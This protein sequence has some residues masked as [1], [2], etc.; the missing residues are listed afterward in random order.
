MIKY[1]I[2][3][4]GCAM[5]YSD[6][7]RLCSI[8]DSC[9]GKK[10]KT[11]REA[12]LLLCNTCSI[13]QKSEDKALGF[14]HQTKK[15]L[16]NIKIVLSGC[17]VR[18][19]GVKAFGSDKLLKHRFIDATVRIEDLAKMPKILSPLFPSENFASFS[20]FYDRGDID[21]YFHIKPKVKNKYQVSVPIMRGCDNFCTY[22]IV[23]LTRG[24]EISR[25]LKE[26]ISECTALVKNGAQELTLVGQ[27]VNSYQIK[28]KKC[29]PL[30]LQEIDKLYNSGLRWL[31]FVSPNPRDWSE[32][33]TSILAQMRLKFPYLHLPLQ[34]GSDHILHKMNRGY[35]K[36]QYISLV[37]KIR[38]KLPYIRI[39]TDIIVGFPGES[40]ADFAS[41]CALAQELK[42]DFVYL[43]IFSP[44][45]GTGAA[46]MTAEFI[47][48]KTKKERF[49]T[50]DKIIQ[51]HAFA[52]RKAMIGKTTEILISSCQKQKNGKYLC[53]GRTAEYYET[54][55]ESSKDLTG[56]LLSIKIISAKNYVLQ[57]KIILPPSPNLK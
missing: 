44:R 26:I 14:F 48:D 12:D 10:V 23:P 17:M 42:F 39:A 30:L 41:T 18:R 40:Q 29:F 1:Y 38:E 5:N 16:P 31:R 9:Q 45:E 51:S 4:F 46:E 2:Q 13:R 11:L 21:N 37:T 36:K 7:E 24:R 8:M 15:I 32:E 47:A 33:T 22:C 55:S 19:T 35:T 54:Y 6:S 27:N 20:K 49:H 57:G 25:P 28:G 34:S 43:A 56:Q 52:A 50:L 53:S 3:T